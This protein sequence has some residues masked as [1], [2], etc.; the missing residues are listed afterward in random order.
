VVSWRAFRGPGAG[1][2]ALTLLS[3]V[4]Y[5]LFDKEAMA[6][7]DSVDVGPLP[8]AVVFYFLLCAG[9]LVFFLPLALPQVGV[10][11]LALTL[12]KEWRAALA[13]AAVSFVG[14]GL[15]LEAYRTAPASYVVAVRQSSVLFAMVLGVRLLGEGP[16]RAR[17]LGAVATVVGV[18]LIALFP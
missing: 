3:T 2:A 16:G 4:A 10:R 7:L 6:R 18:V 14:Y 5:S 12:R 13:A 8:T 15:I 1:F 9:S 17:T 11:G